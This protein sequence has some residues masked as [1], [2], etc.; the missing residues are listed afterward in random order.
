[1]IKFYKAKKEDLDYLMNHDKHIT[2]EVLQRKIEAHQVIMIK[3]E[4]K[5]IGC[6]RYNLFWDNTPF[7][8]MLMIDEGYR[9]QGI[10]KKAVT[11]WEEEMKKKSYAL[12]MTSTL[13]DE[14]AQHF[15]RK[16]AYRDAGSLILDQ[17]ALEIIFTK[18]I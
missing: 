2:K 16:L 1:M 7:M 6:L 8:N 9:G 4:E 3:K 5:I 17:E 15:Y 11:Y 10:G 13:S 12:V 14:G 18:K